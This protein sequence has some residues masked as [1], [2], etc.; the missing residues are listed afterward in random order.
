M[1]RFLV[2]DPIL[3]RRPGFTRQA[4]RWVR[5][6]PSLVLLA[7]F[8]VLQP[9]LFFL[10]LTIPRDALK[11][12]VEFRPPSVSLGSIVLAV[13]L[14]AVDACSV[15]LAVRFVYFPTPGTAR[16]KRALFL[17]GYL[18]LSSPAESLVIP[19]LLGFF[20]GVGKVGIY[21]WW[22]FDHGL[23][24]GLILG[25]L[26]MLASRLTRG[27]AL[28]SVVFAILGGLFV[29]VGACILGW[30]LAG[31]PDG[32]VGPGYVSMPLFAFGSALLGGILSRRPPPPSLITSFRG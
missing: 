21:L 16:W 8:F 24:Q 18:L 29:L 25:G 13:G 22:A 6:H 9:V 20:G 5:R 2:G 12:F 26:G 28:L 4:M 14:L 17:L 1:E 27:S 7:G 3:G 11:G 30:L 32:A 10:S 19:L 23:G 15:A 31:N